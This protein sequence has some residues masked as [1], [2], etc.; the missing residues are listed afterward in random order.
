MRAQAWRSALRNGPAPARIDEPAARRSVGA[1]SGAELRDDDLAA[2]AKIAH[3]VAQRDVVAGR[4]ANRLG[5]RRRPRQHRQVLDVEAEADGGTVAAEDR[6][7]LVVA[8]TT[9]DSVA[10]ATGVGGEAGATVV[11]VAA[12]IGEVEADAGARMAP[13]G[14]R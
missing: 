13:A 10:C 1:G 6:A 7:D 8:A 14:T 12:R 2:R 11:G 3:R 5:W 9:R 4:S